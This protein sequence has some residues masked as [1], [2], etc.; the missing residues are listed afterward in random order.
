M[1]NTKRYELNNFLDGGLSKVSVSVSDFRM[2]QE[3][4][5]DA[6]EVARGEEFK[7]SILLE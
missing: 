7:K 1:S 3:E 5:E 4:T 2:S 6:G